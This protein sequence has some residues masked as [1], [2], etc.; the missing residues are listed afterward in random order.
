MIQQWGCQMAVAALD[1][2]GV[3]NFAFQKLSET[4]AV[5]TATIHFLVKII[6]ASFPIHG[7]ESSAR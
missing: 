3:T 4:A 5:E 7:L 1:K 2:V 6:L